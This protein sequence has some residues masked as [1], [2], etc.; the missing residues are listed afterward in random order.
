MLSIFIMLFFKKNTYFTIQ[1][2]N[3]DT[4]VY[5]LNFSACDGIIGIPLRCLWGSRCVPRVRPQRAGYVFLYNEGQ[6]Q[7]FNLSSTKGN[8][9]LFFQIT[10]AMTVNQIK[11]YGSVVTSGEYLMG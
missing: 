10:E 7:L 6:Q 4:S 5:M 2:V 9:N 11:M 8:R 1:Y 3:G